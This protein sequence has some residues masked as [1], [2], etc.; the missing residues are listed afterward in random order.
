MH[1][2]LSSRTELALSSSDEVRRLQYA[3]DLCVTCL[4]TE[5]LG[6]SRELG[7][8]RPSPESLLCSSLKLPHDEDLC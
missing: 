8:V 2:A 1:A 6:S 5:D 7:R 4:D 3:N